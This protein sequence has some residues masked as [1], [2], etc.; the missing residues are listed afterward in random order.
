MMKLKY[1]LS[2]FVLCSG[3][4]F[5]ATQILQPSTP[6]KEQDGEKVKL[7]D[8]Y[9]AGLQTTKQSV[10][11]LM[12]IEGAADGVPYG[13][14]CDE[15]NDRSVKISWNTPEV[16]DGYFDDFEDHDNFAV[17]SPGKVGWSYI[18]GDNK[19]TYTWSAT[20]FKNQGKKM[21]FIVMNPSECTPSVEANPKYV[22]AS[23]K[24]MLATMCAIDAP[25]NDWIISPRLN[26]S[27]DFKFSFHAKSYRTDGIA[28]ERIRVGYSTTGKTQSSFKFVTPAPYLE[29][30]DTWDL[31]EYIIPKEATYVCI[32]CVSDDAFM[33]LLDD[34]MIATNEIRPNV[35]SDPN[36]MADAG[37]TG[38]GFAGDAAE[39]E[40]S[41]SPAKVKG[42][43]LVGFNV[44][45][46]GVKVNKQTVTEVRYTDIADTYAE[47]SYTVT[48][49]Y[50]DG[51]ESAQSQPVKVDVIDPRLL[52]FEDDFDDWT[53]HAD[54][55]STPENPVGTESYWSID[56]YTYGLI[57]PAATYGYSSLHNYDQS[58]VSR[59]LR[60]LDRNT[61]YLR[62]DLRLCNW[63]Q[64]ED[65][66]SYLA[67]E[68]TSDGGKTWSTIDTYDNTKGEFNW[69]VKQY[70]LKA[71]LKSDNFQLRWRA[72]GVYA[73]HIDY[74]Y[75]DDVK[76]WNPVWG[77]LKM[78]VNSADGPVQNARVK[79]T[80]TTGGVQELTTDASGVITLGQIEADTYRVDILKDG[81]NAYTGTIEVKED[82]TA[83]PSVHITRPVLELSKT[84][85]QPD[86]AVEDKVTESFVVKNTGD[87]PLTWRLNYT[88]TKQSGKA[89]DFEINRTWLA[90][91]DVQTS[92][93]FDGEYYYTT[94]WYYL[95][96]FWKYDREGNLIEQFRIPDM[97]YRL[98]DLA[99]DGRYFYGSDY[100]NRLFQLDFDNKRIVGI[101]EITNAPDLQITH[102]AYNP[103]NDRFYVGGWNTLCEVR[104]NG[105]ASSMAVAF[106]EN[107]GHSIYGSAYDNVTPGGPYLWLAAEEGYNEY[108]LDNVVIYQYDLNKKKFTGVKKPVTDLPG[109]VVGSVTA[110]INNICGIEGSYDVASGKYT[111]VGVLQQS[112]CLFF[113][114]NVAEVDT[115]L[116]YSPKKTTLAPGESATVTVNIDAREA[117]VGQTFSHKITVNTVPELSAQTVTL[118]Y[119]ATKAS[120][121]PRP[122]NLAA[123]NIVPDQVVLTWSKPAADPSSYIIYRDGVQIGT[124]SSLTYTD[125]GVVRGTYTYEVTAVY[126]GKES[127][128]S[129][130]IQFAVKQGAPFY[131]PL[132][133]A[134][135]LTLN[136]DVSLS[137][138]SPLAYAQ[139]NATL[140][141][142]SG[143]H[144]DQVGMASGGTFFVGAVWNATDFVNQRGKQIV[145]A[146]VRIVNPLTY[147]AACIFKD[148]QLI[149]RQQFEGSVTYGAWN[150]VQFKTPVDIVAGSD[151][152]VAFQVEHAEG[153]QPIGIDGSKEVDG[154]GNMLS[155]DGDYW[156]PATQ[157]AIDGNLCIKF[158]VR[159]KGSNEVAPFGYNVYRNG[160]KVNQSPVTSTTFAEKL[161]LGGL[162]QYAVSSV[163]P[164]GESSLSN[165]TELKVQSIG[166]RL[167]PSELATDVICNR[168]VTLYWGFPIQGKSSFPI[169]IKAPITTSISG[170]PTYVNAF[171]GKGSEMGVASDCKFIYTSS[172][173]EDGRINKYSL[174]GQFV[175]HFYIKGLDGI[176][177][178]T[179]DGK[180]FWVSTVDT[181]IYKVDMERHTILE[182]RPI[183]EYA[184]HLTYIP[185]LD[186]GKGGFEVGDWESSIYT[187]R[188]GSKIATG[189]TLKGACGTAY[190]DGRLYAFEQG[191]S[192]P[193]TIGIYDFR[194][195]QRI[196]QIDLADYTGLSSIESASAGGMSVIHTPEG[197]TILAV[198]IQNSLA[199][200]QFLFLD[201]GG[202]T[203]V[204]GYNVYRNGTKLNTKPV[205]QRFF[206]ER[207]T[208]EGDYDYQI[209]T[210]YID[211]TVSA[212]SAAKRVTILP[213]G[214][215]DAPIEVRAEATS[216]GYNVAVSFAD[217]ALPMSAALF[218][219]FEDQAADNAASVRGWDNVGGAW[220]ITTDRAYHGKLSI[221][222]NR[223]DEAILVIPAESMGWMSLFAKNADDHYGSGNIQ[224][225]SSEDDVI[226]N[227][228]LVD[229]FSTTELWSECNVELPAG[230]R[231]VMVRKPAGIPMGYVDGIR[232]NS[233]AP[234]SKVWGYD[235]FR[236]GKQ[237]NTSSIRSVS[238]M[239]HNVTPGMYTYQA[240][241]QSVTAAIS[242]L[243]E[244]F[245]LDLQYSNGGQVPEN[246]R[247]LDY[248]P[249]RTELA[250]ETPALGET[251][252]LKWHTGNTYDAAG[253]PNGG[254][255]YAGVRWLASDLKDYAHLT[256]SEV[257]VYIN[258][259][260]DALYLLVYQGKD[261]VSTQYV[262]DLKQYSFN[263]ITL[264]KPIKMDTSRDLRV[265]VYVEHNE[266]TVPLG[267]DEGPAVTGRGNI[268]STDGTS[269][270]TLDGEDSG[271]DGNWNI[272]IGLK[273]FLDVKAKAQKSTVEDQSVAPQFA[274]Y[275]DFDSD[276]IVPHKVKA[277]ALQFAT[278]HYD[279]QRSSLNTLDGYN[280]YANNAK[281][282]A[283]LIKG[284]CYTDT[285]D[286]S[287]YP[288]VQFKASAVYSLLG[289]VFTPTVTIST[290]GVET[291]WNSY[292]RV[293]SRDGRLNVVGAQKGDSVKVFDT[294]GR[295]LYVG[296]ASGSELF[297]LPQ[298]FPVGIYV[299]SVGTYT[300]KGVVR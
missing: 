221:S 94:S 92:I 77:S 190:H 249:G 110:G 35:M 84:I 182:E 39:G 138:K 62:F 64:Y 6:H 133:L 241:Q 291:M 237:L 121:T 266:I 152:I 176:R 248:Q 23:G 18:D 260:P 68:I 292:V 50:S 234:D 128:K 109:Y 218:Q 60:T 126:A 219:S 135:S 9:Y 167:S 154:K 47:H 15:V 99:Y 125:E 33:M 51:S 13:L 20:S 40:S 264:D 21:A 26:F 247:V 98:Y 97:Y 72:Y 22:P 49:L 43:H 187:N 257:E 67:L 250:W 243:S 285:N 227:F 194:T 53:L 202:V 59:E 161:S 58:L 107:E 276:A 112:P 34:I 239:D 141:W 296:T 300:C 175:E 261:L 95:G 159:T 32:N 57:D 191:G 120:Q 179:F 275:V 256:L 81:Y 215:A 146:S 231:Y 258:L 147:L 10:Y 268:Y 61:T 204:S 4:A 150:T 281:V 25:N 44:Y 69:T 37:T 74:W 220:R 38:A 118:G 101:I 157:M 205:T 283:E 286:Y 199:N 119:Q 225:L 262:H 164:T 288:F 189:P 210:T 19:N 233:M 31:Y 186:G 3:F 80:G 245:C 29:L 66:V 192:N 209:E 136:Q 144:A 115:W 14:R 173:N 105:R 244:L 108:M 24:K 123:T 113:E 170:Y 217:P 177:N 111:L 16:V 42:T 183:S 208:T 265:I 71:Y 290:T 85:V 63:G 274:E 174:N 272:S 171:Q 206:E 116:D 104:R 88:P 299:V 196:G 93:A 235:V 5:A 96:E 2:V 294:N 197:L 269:W 240:R 168:D 142:G 193:Y 238:Y 114:Y 45:R 155:V 222:A 140:M 270:T 1:I 87:G 52:P 278:S 298:Q 90:S 254:S 263:R 70:P 169:D 148:G 102:V 259:V 224:I 293:G 79:L 295:Q 78:T 178:I 172:Y 279:G 130:A 223:D 75:V 11:P 200:T 297:T 162:Y 228:I 184:R 12:K 236:D 137:W 282:N 132:E 253:L 30:P 17:N 89:L 103:N 83:T 7:S 232:L 65:E 180:D 166:E 151:Y 267:Y 198:C 76:V 284:T 149:V 46:D 289:E 134:S 195:S 246:F 203:G 163:Y 27:E 271:I 41:S 54:K 73:L 139:Q 226:D 153:L 156:F 216:Y 48:A 273:P 100:S 86:M 255:F 8:A 212:K 242:P 230:T 201:L 251:L 181:Y 165:T 211:G 287:K 188:I 82:Q 160:V 117:Q 122:T 129:D 91:G 213:I 229:E 145:S 185:D 131:A 106:D 127:V 277:T 252:Y 56:Y 143:E 207:L 214:T 28:P 55:W 124:S 280:V 158:D 36:V